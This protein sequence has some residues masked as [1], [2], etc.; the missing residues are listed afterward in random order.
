MKIVIDI[1]EAQYEDMKVIAGLHHYRNELTIEQTIVAGEPLSI[2]DCVS[3]KAMMD[4]FKKW[5]PYMATRLWEFEQELTSLPSIP[6]KQKIGHWIYDEA[7]SDWFDAT[8][9][10]SCCK[11]S[12]IIPYELTNVPY[13]A[14]NE[15]YKDY[16]Y[17]HCGARMI[18]PQEEE[19]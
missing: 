10:C 9:E 16:P 11:R 5:Q 18:D 8:Y 1:P 19:E 14:L 15:V 6:P 3:R 13:E 2:E 17:C 4:C 12:I 7:R